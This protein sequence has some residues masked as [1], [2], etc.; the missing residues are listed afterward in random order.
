MT[1]REYSMFIPPHEYGLTFLR[2]G[3]T[4]GY[5]IA[6][7]TTAYFGKMVGGLFGAKGAGFTWRESATVGTLLSCKG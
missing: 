1:V 3:K 5:T 4:W 6:I 2:S 7:I